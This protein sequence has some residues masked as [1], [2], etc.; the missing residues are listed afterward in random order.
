MS[1]AT[2]NDSTQ[3]GLAPIWVGLAIWLFFPLGLFLLWRHPNLGKN[4]KWW[5]A[6]IAWACFIMLMASRAEKGEPGAEPDPPVTNGQITEP[7][8]KNFT[9]KQ[10][11]VFYKKAAQL[12]LGMSA[13]DVFGIMGTPTKRWDFDPTKDLPAVARERIVDP[14]VV[15]DYK[16]CSA[17]DPENDFVSVALKDGEVFWITAIKDGAKFVDL[18]R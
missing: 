3:G 4:G 7:S 6:G 16:W 5:A 9:T 8:G 10:M 14:R 18:K 13:E 12:R 1:D 15:V 2:G 11:E 17:K